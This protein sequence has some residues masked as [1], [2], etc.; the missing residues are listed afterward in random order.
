ME[1]HMRTRCSVLVIGAGLGGIAAA[2]RLARAGFSVTVLEKNAAPGGR[3][4]QF[5]RDGHR[6]DVGPTLFLMPEVFAETYADLGERMGDHL[7]L[8]RIDPTYRIHFDD[9]LQLALTS[10]LHALEEQL[11]ALEPRSF[12]GLLRYLAEGHQHY[13]LALE[14]FVGRNFY[15]LL[16]Y[17]SPQNL[18]LLLKLKAL[19]R[20]YDN[21]GRYFQHPPPPA[22]SS[23]SGTPG[24]HEVHVLRHH[25]LLGRG[26]RVCPAWRP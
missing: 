8:R 10:D 7:D 17:F 26:S 1:S 25:V 6:F 13:D 24:A 22:R 11:E 19:T 20:H 4:S 9:G 3:C 15:S 14:R 5:I 2:A 18:P 21:I 23:R 16:D 12:D